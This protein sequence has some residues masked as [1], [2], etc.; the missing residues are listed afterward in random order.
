VMGR[1]KVKA[2]KLSLTGVM[3]SHHATIIVVHRQISPEGGTPSLLIITREFNGHSHGTITA[4]ERGNHKVRARC[5]RRHDD[6][7]AQV[8]PPLAG[9]MYWKSRVYTFWLGQ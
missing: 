2:S 7:D 5:R 6:V 8:L 3:V 9:C 1:K 4:R